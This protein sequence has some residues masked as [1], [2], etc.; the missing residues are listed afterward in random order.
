MRKTEPAKPHNRGG[1]WYLVR[2]VPAEYQHLD[3][4]GLVRISTDI[5]VAHDPRGVKAKD[6]VRQLDIELSAYWRGLL[7]GQAAAAR[8][9]FEAAAKRARALNLPYRTAGELAADA[10]VAEILA[11]L[12]LLTD[13]D[14]IEAE[15]EVAA[16]LGGEPRPSFL[17]SDLVDEFEAIHSATLAKKAP[18]QVRKWRN[19]K[20]RAVKNLIS[21]VTDKALKDLTRADGVAF[22]LYWQ[23]RVIDEELDIGTANKDIGHISKMLRDVEM[24]H[25]LGLPPVFARLRLEG[26]QQKQRAAFTIEHVRDRILAAG[27]LDKLNEEARHLIYLIIETGLRPAEAVNLTEDTIQLNAEVPHVQ[28]RADGRQMK[29]DHSAR[30]LPLVG[31]ALVVMKLHP[32]GFPRYRHNAD[33]LSA[34]VNKVLDNAGL[35]PTDNHSLYSLRHTFE[36]RLTAVEAPEKVTA[37]LMGHKWHRPKYGAGPSLAQKHEWLTRIA[38]T[39]PA[40][41]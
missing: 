28:V 23:R 7:D 1:V 41:V 4:R 39:P 11:R 32:G 3:R 21:V 12:R 10:P 5:A 22:R 31:V 20:K 15:A 6:V 29:T 27:A 35:L 18:D 36:D 38:F 16:V 34:I 8:I 37:M 13:A 30:D 24:T 25:Q 9:R 33:A 14:K 26:E 2:R 19:P 17:I 40:H